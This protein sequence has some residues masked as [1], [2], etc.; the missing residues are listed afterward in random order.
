[1]TKAVQEKEPDIYTYFA[2]HAKGQ[3]GKDEI[4]FVEKYVNSNWH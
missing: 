3:D 4:V 1:L 2:F